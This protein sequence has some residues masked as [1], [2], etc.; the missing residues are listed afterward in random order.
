MPFFTYGQNNSGGYMH[1]D[2]GAGISH[3]VIVEADDAKQADY[4]A[5]GIGLYFDGIE[6]GAD[7][8]CCGDRW[9]AQDSWWNTDEGDEVPTVYG[10]P[11]EST[12]LSWR[13]LKK[14]LPEVYIHYADGTF[15]GL[16]D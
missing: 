3:Y 13:S 4:K 9:C 6:K 1:F 16:H 11:V 2:A 8:D 5:I 10:E 12:D 7:C 14:G 15:K